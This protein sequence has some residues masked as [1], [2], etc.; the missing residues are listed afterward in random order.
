MF[1]ALFQH[2]EQPWPASHSLNSC[3]RKKWRKKFQS[4]QYYVWYTGVHRILWK[5]RGETHSQPD[6]HRKTSWR[7]W[8][9]C[10]FLKNDIRVIQVCTCRKIITDRRKSMS[11][12]SKTWKRN[13]ILQEH[14]VGGQKLWVVGL[15]RG[16][17]VWSHG[18]EIRDSGRQLLKESGLHAT[19]VFKI[20][21]CY[22]GNIICCC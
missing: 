13:V 11:R 18:G 22:S 10:C 8:C 7:R 9:S 21:P 17:L 4:N 6:S 15:E 19:Y 2:L 20:H 12:E 5:H 1:C 16:S 14:E 3:G